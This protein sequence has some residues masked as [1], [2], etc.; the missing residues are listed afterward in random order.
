MGDLEGLQTS[1]EE[2][3][4]G[5]VETVRE[6]EWEAKPEDGTDLLQSQ[7]Q[8]WRDEELLLMDEQRKWFP[9]M[10]STPGEDAVKIIEMMTEDLE[11]YVNLVD[12]AVAVFERMDSFW[13]KS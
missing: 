11:Y 7:H 10:E 6:L 8:T 9:E 12:K 3:T 4:A 5:V 2:V 1:V 13:K